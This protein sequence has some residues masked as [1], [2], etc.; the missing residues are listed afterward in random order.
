MEWMSRR[1]SKRNNKGAL[2]SG[3]ARDPVLTASSH[4]L[5]SLQRSTRKSMTRKRNSQ[6]LSPM[7]RHWSRKETLNSSKTRYSLT[8]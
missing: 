7:K 3:N 2:L 6:K 8:S 5:L 1:K 4:L